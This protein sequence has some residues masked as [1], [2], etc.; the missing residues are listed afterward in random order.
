M[1]ILATTPYFYPEGGGLENYAYNIFR[2]LVKQGHK[3]V[4]FC[5][6][7]KGIDRTDNID[8]IVVNRLKPDI[9]I[10]NTPIRANL[11]SILSRELKN[12][13]DIVNSHTPVPY[14]AEV[15][16]LAAYRR[17]IPY[18]ITYHA[19][20]LL[21]R[22]WVLN[23]IA[24]IHRLTIESAAFSIAE[25]IITVSEFVRNHYLSR[26]AAKVE[27][28]P[29]G[30]DTNRFTPNPNGYNY[31]GK[32]LLFIGSLDPAYE[33]KGLRVLL[34]AMP[35]VTKVH[36]NVVL[37]IIG[38]GVLKDHYKRLCKNLGIDKNVIFR[39]RLSSE[40][41]LE[42]Y[43]RSTLLILPST[44]NAEAFPLV[45][46]E[47]NSCGIPVIASNVGGVPSAVR[48]NV[49]GFLVQPQD[50][51]ALSNKIIE[52]SNNPRLLLRLSDSSKRY[53]KNFDWE[54]AATHTAKLFSEVIDNNKYSKV[55]L[56]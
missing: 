23:I 34:N 39:G 45:I 14:F 4:V 8:G 38:D 9:I 47:A 52:L 2:N 15:A 26:F 12:G 37:E 24:K 18:I 1:K 43:Q 33:W 25:K 30:I 16:A 53:V 13:Y 54:I 22:N 5:S 36:P 35:L 11:F 7:K 56:V 20:E 50:H 44:T 31:N 29:P 55:E 10:S 17:K 3:V 41:L 40:D 19:G 51:I 27:I 21:G 28:I 32:R 49:N 46:L 42:T 48:D 6:T